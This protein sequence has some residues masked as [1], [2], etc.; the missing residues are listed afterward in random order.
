MT[1][2]HSDALPLAGTRAR[3]QALPIP[4]L[5]SRS[6]AARS[7]PLLAS[8]VAALG[9][10]GLGCANLDLRATGSMVAGAVLRQP[11]ESKCAETKLNGCPE[12]VSALLLYAGGDKVNAEEQLRVVAGKN[13]PEDLRTFARAI[14]TLGQLPGVEDKIKPVLEAARFILELP[15][16]SGGTAVASAPGGTGAPEGAAPGSRAKEGPTEAPAAARLALTADTDSSRLEG[17]LLVPATRQDCRACSVLGTS[18]VCVLAFEGPLIVTDL[19]AP[20][21]CA[22][23][24]FAVGAVT[25]SDL[26]A[27]RW[28]VNGKTEPLP[29][30]SARLLVREGEALFVGLAGAANPKQDRNCALMWRGFRPYDSGGPDKSA[31]ALA[32]R[33]PR[34]ATGDI[35]IDSTPACAAISID[36]VLREERTPAKVQGLARGPHGIELSLAHHA[37]EQKMIEVEPGTTP[38]WT[39]RLRQISGKV[40]F[41][42]KP[43]GATVLV[44]ELEVGTTPVEVE[45]DACLHQIRLRK[46]LYAE[47]AEVVVV[48]RGK[49]AQVGPKLV[50]KFGSLRVVALERGRPVEGAEVL[51]SGQLRGNAPLSLDEVEEGTVTVEVRAPFHRTYTAEV[52]IAPGPPAEVKAQLVPEYGFVQV[53]ADQAASFEIDGE[54]QGP[55]DGKSIKLKIGPHKVAIRPEQAALYSAAEREVVI[56]ALG[57]ELVDGHLAPRL[58]KLSVLSTPS[59]AA[60]SVSGVE[61]GQT[62]GTLALFAG[63]IQFQLKKEGYFDWAGTAIVK[64]GETANVAVDLKSIA[65]ARNEEERAGKHLRGWLVGAA[66]VLV[67]AGAGGAY[68]LA[69]GS[70]A[71]AQ[72][73]LGRYR[74]ATT[75]QQITTQREA[76]SAANSTA[77]SQNVAAI[78][79]AATAGALVS[80][81]IYEFWSAP[82][83]MMG[84]AR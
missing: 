23:R 11:L 43:Q 71:E 47:H 70:A 54:A 81:A 39:A 52:K 31:P 24:L 17:E 18:G 42:S 84:E 61:H 7:A 46:K 65:V 5:S 29:L 55:A 22:E 37:V 1:A 27:P 14:N 49:V 12:L 64:E 79:L 19:S 74:A 45:V 58:G 10:A 83:S 51:V 56:A 68:A 44:D 20:G 21:G 78:A 13:T 33:T 32:A 76:V 59:G 28:V 57:T 15:T 4:G 34:P 50:A 67:G 40:A 26:G 2:T 63:T 3:E 48:E 73:A 82:A 69:S 60:L 6:L 66:G 41:D 38:S 25:E 35:S 36:G 80:W 16:G 9:G 62:P 75:P 77:R 72:T 8:L 53:R 30:R